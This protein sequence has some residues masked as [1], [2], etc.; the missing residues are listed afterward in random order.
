MNILFCFENIFT[1]TTKSIKIYLKQFQNIPIP[2]N[3]SIYY[4]ITQVLS[5]IIYFILK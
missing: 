1:K 5:I 2:I 3:N 4:R